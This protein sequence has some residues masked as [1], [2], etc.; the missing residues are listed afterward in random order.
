MVLKVRWVQ[1]AGEE[2]KMGKVLQA[3]MVPMVHWVQLAGE[4]SM[5]G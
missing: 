1:L 3:S 4:E 5:A 2:H